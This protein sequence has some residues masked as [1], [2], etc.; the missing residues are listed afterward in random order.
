MKSKFVRGDLVKV[1]DEM[2]LCMKHF[3]AGF[4]GIVVNLSLCQDQWS[5]GL[6]GKH[7]YTSWYDEYQLTKAADR[8][9]PLLD[10]VDGTTAWDDCTEIPK[11]TTA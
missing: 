8:S 5:Y 1:D 4:L 6:L 9:M 10:V 3:Q 2:P 7:G 11:E